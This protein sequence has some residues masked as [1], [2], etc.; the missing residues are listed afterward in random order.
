[1]AANLLQNLVFRLR[2]QSLKRTIERA[3]VHPLSSLLASDQVRAGDIVRVDYHTELKRMVFAKEGTMV[4][5]AA[6]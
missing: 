4:L 6:A 3:L 1:M 2:L 5:G